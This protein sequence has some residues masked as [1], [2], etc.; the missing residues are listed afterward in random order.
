MQEESR[1]GHHFH[2]ALLPFADLHHHGVSSRISV[3]PSNH[4]TV[5]HCNLDKLC[6][7]KRAL[8]RLTKPAQI[9]GTA[10]LTA[11]EPSFRPRNPVRPM[12]TSEL[13]IRM[14]SSFP[15]STP[16]EA[17]AWPTGDVRGPFADF[18]M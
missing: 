9:L 1:L 6:R 13:S 15:P 2:H 7:S 10:A 11:Q 18:T 4:P 8:F 3:S 16:V 14:P 17:L 12:S 5:I